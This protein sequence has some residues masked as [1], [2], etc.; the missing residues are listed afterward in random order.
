MIIAVLLL[1]AFPIVLIFS[2]SCCRMA[3][4]NDPCKNCK[5]DKCTECTYWREMT[6]DG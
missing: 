1:V 5:H 6:G 3:A 2:L 4:E